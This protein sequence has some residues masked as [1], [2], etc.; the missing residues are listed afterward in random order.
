MV[1]KAFRKV[2]VAK[3]LHMYSPCGKSVVF[4]VVLFAGAQIFC[5]QFLANSP[6]RVSYSS[7]LDPRSCKNASLVRI[8]LGWGSTRWFFLARFG[9]FSNVRC[10]TPALQVFPNQRQTL[11]R[12][13]A[14]QS[15]LSRPNGSSL[16]T[17]VGFFAN[18]LSPKQQQGAASFP[19]RNT[20]RT[21]SSLPRKPRT[22][23]FLPAG[24]SA[25]FCVLPDRMPTTVARISLLFASIFSSSRRTFAGWQFPLLE[26][27]PLPPLFFAVFLLFAISLVSTPR[28]CWRTEALQELFLCFLSKVLIF[29]A[30]LRFLVYLGACISKNRCRLRGIICPA[31]PTQFCLLAV[32]ASTGRP[33]LGRAVLV[34]C[35]RRVLC[36]RFR[37]SCSNGAG[38]APLLLRLRIGCLP[39]KLDNS[40]SQSPP[41]PTR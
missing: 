36:E 40:E 5:R 24:N 28:L 16:H 8:P 1:L 38:L 25:T 32:E 35:T 10:T 12:K 13:A 29:C 26:P 39:E 27:L 3:R 19:C 21:L 2:V 20:T 17:L 37:L 14:D 6:R 7:H 15:C 18:L 33:R 9:N 11:A 34:F 22:S 23:H 30:V 4:S 31:I 41:L